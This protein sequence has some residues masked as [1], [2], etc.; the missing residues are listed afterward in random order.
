M[1]CCSSSIRPL[2][3]LLLVD[4]IILLSDKS[5]KEHTEGTQPLP[6]RPSPSLVVSSA[7][8]YRIVMDSR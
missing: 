6:L 3:I 4:I 1:T 7:D 5:L 8:F 2:L